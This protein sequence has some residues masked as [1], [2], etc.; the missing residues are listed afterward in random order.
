MKV[1]FILLFVAAVC[2]Q[3]WARLSQQTRAAIVSRVQAMISHAQRAMSA[4]S[5]KVFRRRTA[6]R[7]VF[8][9]DR[10]DLNPAGRVIVAHLTKFCFL[11]NT[12]AQGQAD[13]DTMMRR[14][15]RRQVLIE[16]MRELHLD[17][18]TA[19]QAVQDEDVLAA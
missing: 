10:G 12:T 18:S 11:L 4:L 14:E 6:Y 2:V 15:G 3:V 1:A 7:N 8:L 19:L 5:A 17:P 16:I 13:R 9:N